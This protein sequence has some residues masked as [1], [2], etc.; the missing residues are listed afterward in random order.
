ML[1]RPDRLTFTYELEGVVITE[2]KFF[3]DDDVLLN[4]VTLSNTSAAKSVLLTLEGQSYANMKALPSGSKDPSFAKIPYP[5]PTSSVVNATVSLDDAFPTISGGCIACGAVRVDE[6]GAGWSKPIDCK[7]AP[8]PEGID[9]L[10]KEGEM[11][12][13][14]MAVFVATSVALSPENA[15][16]GRDWAGRATYNITVP[17]T[18]ATPLVLGWVMGDDAASTRERIA[19]YMSPT[20]AAAALAART[21][22]ALHFLTVK[23]PQLS[24]TLDESKLMVDG[25]AATVASSARVAVAPAPG[26]DSASSFEYRAGYTCSTSKYAFINNQTAASCQTACAADAQCVEFKLKLTAPF[27]CTLTNASGAS[28]PRTAPGYGCGCKGVCPSTPT[29]P[30]PSPRPSPI[31]PMNR[32]LDFNEAYYFGWAMYWMMLLDVQADGTF[33][34]AGGHA[35]ASKLFHRRASS[36]V[37][38]S[39]SLLDTAP[40]FRVS[41]RTRSHCFSAP[42]VVTL[43]VNICPFKY[44]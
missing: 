6:S 39:S 29:P 36:T 18:S 33:E 19:K 22:D 16:L 42:S 21:A 9:C 15:A 5:T 11:M 12:Y 13:S 14:G 40:L 8:F 1:W 23:V 38:F 32:T 27:W 41:P 43:R 28:P 3:T 37:L 20:A 35:Q 17:I 7:F 26:S 34:T 4:I 24:V 30:G 10:A 2:V 44:E 25:R 31:P